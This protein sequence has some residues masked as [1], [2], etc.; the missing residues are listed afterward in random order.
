MP[1]DAPASLN[2]ASEE[3]REEW[4]RE[5]ERQ[6]MEVQRQL[7][8]DNVDADR[9]LPNPMIERS[10]YMRRLQAQLRM[11]S[12][13]SRTQPTGDPFGDYLSDVTYTIE[14]GARRMREQIETERAGVERLS[15]DVVCCIVNG[16]YLLIRRTS[17]VDKQDAGA[18]RKVAEEDVR[19][20]LL[21]LRDLLKSFRSTLDGQSVSVEGGGFLSILKKDLTKILMEG[22]EASLI[23]LLFSV[24]EVIARFAREIDQE[25]TSVIHETRC[26]PLMRI[27]GS[28][29][30]A[31]FGGASSVVSRTRG[32][33]RDV[34]VRQARNRREAVLNVGLGGEL[35]AERRPRLSRRTCQLIDGRDALLSA[36]S[37]VDLC[38]IDP[39]PPRP[40]PEDQ[41]PRGDNTGQSGGGDDDSGGRGPT[42]PGG[43]RPPSRPAG[44][45]DRP[46]GEGRTT[47]PDLDAPLTETQDPDLGRVGVLN[48]ES[49][50]E[51]Y[52]YLTPTNTAKF[53]VHAFGVDPD[54]ALSMV[55]DGNCQDR[56]SE[57]TEE[58]LQDMGL[59]D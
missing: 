43:G 1:D 22:I 37:V 33:L 4:I 12:R 29:Y 17:S 50:T 9:P 45:G 47:R 36:V 55:R 56:L 40:S 59:I 35:N 11:D 38:R 14:E 28:I 15:G 10:S 32:Y 39:E 44:E 41:E 30:D 49:D 53:M 20:W 58:I 13:P 57:E 48:L 18:A 34:L 46:G 6:L 24:H 26:A 31:L 52:L 8:L 7:G 25:V 5:T 27:W 19:K 2:D 16:L 54:E 21:L 42:S 3:V 23:S 51:D